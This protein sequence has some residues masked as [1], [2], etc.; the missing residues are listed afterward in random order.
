MFAA[1][2]PTRLLALM[3]ALGLIQASAA[4]AAT[5]LKTCSELEL[6]VAALFKVGTASLHLA[7]CS[8]VD[9]ILD[10]IPKRFSLALAREFSG[11]DL[12]EAARDLL[13]AN[14]GLKSAGELPQSLACMAD[15][16]VDAGSGD[17]Y[18]VIYQPGEGLSL[19]LNDRLLRQCENTGAAE[20][21]FM[22]WFGDDPF[23]RRMRD[24]LIDQSLAA[25]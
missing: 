9:R 24:R 18:D 19:Y 11:A 21:Y 15:A 14:L 12:R 4:Y 8:Q 6:R 23:H 20:K 17:R 7:D 5:E 22:I 10:S 2:R 3:M 13:V 16:Y 25:G 1:P